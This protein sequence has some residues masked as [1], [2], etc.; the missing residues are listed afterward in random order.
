[1]CVWG[2][3]VMCMAACTSYAGLLVCRLILGCV[4]VSSSLIPPYVCPSI[5]DKRNPVIVWLSLWPYLHLVL[6]VQEKRD[7]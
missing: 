2:T 6:L 4:E 7:G 1:M 3:I 5:A